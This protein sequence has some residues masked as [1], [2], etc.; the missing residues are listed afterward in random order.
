MQ[1]CLTQINVMHYVCSLQYDMAGELF[2]EGFMH[3][4][5]CFKLA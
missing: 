3:R 5:V 2:D 4:V 1:F